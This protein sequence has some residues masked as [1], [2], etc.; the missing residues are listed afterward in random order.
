MLD[1]QTFIAAATDQQLLE[2]P[3]TSKANIT[4][5][6]NQPTQDASLDANCVLDKL[7]NWASLT[8]LGFPRD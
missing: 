6:P 7:S 2:F 5:I 3:T 8:E 1:T 4:Y